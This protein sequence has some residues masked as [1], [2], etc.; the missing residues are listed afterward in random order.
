VKV[1]WT[2]SAVGHLAAI[3]EYISQTSPFYADRM[4]Q[5]ILDRAP[6]LRAFPE[7][8]QQVPELRRPDIRQVIEGPFRVIYQVTTDQVSILAIVH[9]RRGSLGIDPAGPEQ[10]G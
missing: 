1:V 3:H 5:R 8:G 2:A 10:L 7:S 6:Q 4:V 9:G